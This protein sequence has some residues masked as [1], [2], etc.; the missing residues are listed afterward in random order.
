[1]EEKKS[2]CGAAFGYAT[3]KDTAIR[4]ANIIIRI[5]RTG[6]A[7]PENPAGKEI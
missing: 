5:N 6:S 4:I 2:V 3:G 1:L 7:L